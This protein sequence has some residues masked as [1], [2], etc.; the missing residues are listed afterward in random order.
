MNIE[1]RWV[2]VEPLEELETIPLDEEQLDLVTRI[3]TQANPTVRDRLIHFLRNNLDIFTWGYEEMLG[4]NPSIL[5][6]Q[7]NVSPSFLPVRQRKWVFAQERDNA[8]A[9]KACK[10]LDVNFIWEVYYPEWLCDHDQ[11]RKW[12]VENVRGLHR[13]K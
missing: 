8:I 10:L 1:E 4:I 3:G 9:K 6:H 5:I 7:L 11:E 2:N 12:K 13:P